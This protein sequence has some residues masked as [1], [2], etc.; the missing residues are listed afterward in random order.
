MDKDLKYKKIFVF[1]LILIGIVL[2][3]GLTGKKEAPIKAFQFDSKSNE[4][5]LER[6]LK[7]CA[8][9]S[10][11]K[12]ESL[13]VSEQVDG[14]YGIFIKADREMITFSG[15]EVLDETRDILKCLASD[16]FIF[17]I[18]DND[19]HGII[20]S[21]PATTP[22]GLSSNVNAI[23]YKFT[24]GKLKN[25]INDENLVVPENF[26]KFLE[27]RGDLMLHKDLR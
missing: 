20:I 1:I 16:K 13:E 19:K 18:K 10:P 15:R 25:D 8:N 12:Y 11:K 14:G 7:E 26:I 9:F 24:I 27:S 6:Y 22:E 4:G 21:I 2:Y 17:K 5:K 23:K 3:I